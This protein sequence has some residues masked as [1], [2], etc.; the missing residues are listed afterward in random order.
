MKWALVLLLIAGPAQAD[1]FSFTDRSCTADASITPLGA[2]DNTGDMHA[3]TSSVA[4]NVARG[5]LKFDLSDIPIAA[6]VTSATLKAVYNS[7]N[8][9]NTREFTFVPISAAAIAAK[10]RWVETQVTWINRITATAWTTPGVPFGTEVNSFTVG[11][12]TV[13]GSTYNSHT[14]TEEIQALVSAG[15]GSSGTLVFKF[16][17]AHEDLG[18]GLGIVMATIQGAGS[19]EA[20]LSVTWEYGTPV[21]GFA[22]DFDPV[23]W[24][25]DQDQ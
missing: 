8:I 10:E 19:T 18:S 12:V 4:D 5:I 22:R 1:T 6:T 21:V 9:L 14:I 2:N 24:G 23:P 16:I 3:T 17:A 15:A 11:S 7:E 13:D 25:V 20:L